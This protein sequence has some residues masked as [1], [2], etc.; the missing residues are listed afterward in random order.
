MG[1]LWALLV[2][3]ITPALYLQYAKHDG[4]GALFH[5]GEIWHI[6]ADGVGNY[7]VAVLM[8]LVAMIVAGVVG[9]GAAYL[10]AKIDG[11]VS[12][13]I[14]CIEGYYVR[15]VVCVIVASASVFYA[16]LVSAHLAAQVQPAAAL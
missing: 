7:V 10:I 14:F 16:T 1:M 5:F 4:L 3:F 12:W 15:Y 13:S 11:H 8:T 9:G 2:A 6:M